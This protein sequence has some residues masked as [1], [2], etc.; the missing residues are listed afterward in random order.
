MSGV[1]LIVGLGNPDKH[2]KYTRHNFGFLTMDE[3]A[4]RLKMNFKNNSA[5]Q[6]MVAQGNFEDKEI[7]LFMPLTY[8]NNSGVAVKSLLERKSI[9]L[10][11]VLVVC[12]DLALDFGQMR[13]RPEGSDG[14][15]NGLK[16][17]IG[18]LGSKQF[19]R[20]RLG[21]GRPA[22][23][24]ETVEFVLNQFNPQEKK[25]LPAIIEDAVNCCCLWLSE[26]TSKAMSQFN[27]RPSI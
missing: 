6:G 15:H 21:V 19:V 11:K 26:G 8:M 14:G 1:Y 7:Y 10:D 5:I 2:Y 20:L 17:I 12:D 4:N 24:D 13:L 27:K 16:S 25:Q 23:R 9:A 18:H 3:L 22:N